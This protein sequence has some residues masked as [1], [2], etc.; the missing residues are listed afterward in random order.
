MHLICDK[1]IIIRHY[2]GLFERNEET[3]KRESMRDLSIAYKYT[4]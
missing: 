4:K 3:T 2:T 1:W